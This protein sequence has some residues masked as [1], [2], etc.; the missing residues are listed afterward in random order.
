METSRGLVANHRHRRRPPLPSVVPARRIRHHSPNQRTP[1]RASQT[2]CSESA[3]RAKGDRTIH[4]R[5]AT[6]L[7]LVRTWV[8]AY[9]LS[10]DLPE[11]RLG[12]S[13]QR[14]NV[15][16]ESFVCGRRVPARVA[17]QIKRQIADH[18]IG[19]RDPHW[20]KWIAPFAGS[21]LRFASPPFGKSSVG[22]SIPA[23]KGSAARKFSPCVQIGQ[24]CH[25]TSS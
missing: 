13:R 14:C 1:S 5:E 7:L 4:R 16:F 9:F 10:G 12:H 11:S 18:S 17:T 2:S 22:S 25:Q 23:S 20:S 3:T 21:T 24:S 15:P 19:A 8:L 6:D